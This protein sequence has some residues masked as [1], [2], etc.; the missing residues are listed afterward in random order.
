MKKKKK[1]NL[2]YIFDRHD[3]ENRM[4]EIF[5]LVQIQNIFELKKK[6][7]PINTIQEHEKW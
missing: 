2:E 6:L 1:N 7:L 3:N 5:F 4:M